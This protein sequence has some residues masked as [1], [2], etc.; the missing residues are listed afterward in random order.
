MAEGEC[1]PGDRPHRE[2]YLGPFVRAWGGNLSAEKKRDYL[3]YAR[4]ADPYSREAFD[5]YDRG[6]R[7]AVEV[8]EVVKKF[9]SKVMG[10]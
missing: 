1:R 2:W 8:V 4:A 10:L 7:S 5:A 3:D 6:D 9:V